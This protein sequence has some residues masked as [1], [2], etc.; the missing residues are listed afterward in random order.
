MSWLIAGVLAY[1]ALIWFKAKF[2]RVIKLAVVVI[3]VLISVAMG[4]FPIVAAYLSPGA[5][6]PAI[7]SGFDAKFFGVVLMGVSVVILGGLPWLD[8]SQV[9]SIRYRPSWHK[10]IYIAFAIAFLV[11]GYLGVKPPGVWGSLRVGHYVLLNDIAQAVSQV[12]TFIYFG[13][14]LLMP[15]W[16]AAGQFKQV[17]ERV[18]YHPH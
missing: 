17:P 11:L 9:K 14:F 8:H 5:S 3:A 10:Y 12:C 4:F 15:W 6:L 7:L 18:T 16:S 13:F 1:A 2:S